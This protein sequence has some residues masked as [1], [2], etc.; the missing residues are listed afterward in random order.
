MDVGFYDEN[1]YSGDLTWLDV[2]DDY[3]YSKYYWGSELQGLRF[4]D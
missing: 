3:Y 2:I 1:S 4:R